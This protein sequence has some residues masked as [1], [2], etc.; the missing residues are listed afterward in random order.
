MIP[1]MGEPDF[2]VLGSWLPSLTTYTEALNPKLIPKKSILCFSVVYSKLGDEESPS[3]PNLGTCG[4]ISQICIIP[5]S[6][7]LNPEPYT[8]NRIKP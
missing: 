2:T 1:I 5:L 7:T 8:L 3:P 6:P 4:G